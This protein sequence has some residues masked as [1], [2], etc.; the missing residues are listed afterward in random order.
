MCHCDKVDI[1]LNRGPHEAQHEC[2]KADSQLDMAE[3]GQASQ[4]TNVGA[5]T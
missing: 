2:R 1:A 3:S 4:R 5:E